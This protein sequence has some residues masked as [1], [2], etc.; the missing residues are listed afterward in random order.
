MKERL[1]KEIIDKIQQYD[2]IALFRHVFPDPDSYGAQVALKSIIESTYPNK[3]V[4]LMGQ[5]SQAL[6]YI[7]KMD[8]NM[9]FDKDTLA[10][11]LDV[12]NKERVDHQGFM[13]CGY[14]IKIDHHKPFDAPFE[15][16]TW[17]N[18]EYSATCEMLLEFYLTNKDI[19]N[20][21]KEGR[22]GLFAGIIGDTGRFAYLDNPTEMFKK[23]SEITYDLETK[24]IYANMYKRQQA[25][26][27]FLGYIYSNY[28][29]TENGVAYLMVPKEELLKHGLEPMK[30]VRMVNALQDT[31]GIH[32]WN[33]FVEKPEGGVFCEFRSNGP[34]VNDIAAKY[35]GGGHIFAAGASIASFDVA[36]QMIADFDENCKEYLRN[37]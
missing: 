11:I 28:K 23:L 35:G 32:N 26:L 27:K 7:G 25:E 30:A 6:E 9:V 15:D 20:I 16:L 31:S 18:T 21:T 36:E 33:F 5:H 8:N 10:I 22:K 29:T 34:I 4:A 19:L 12:A 13:D 24:A 17:V 3:K 2:K 37:N 1:F 14:I